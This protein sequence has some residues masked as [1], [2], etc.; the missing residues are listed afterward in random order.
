MS[1]YSVALLSRGWKI[2]VHFFTYPH[3]DEDK[4]IVAFFIALVCKLI[5]DQMFSFLYLFCIILLLWL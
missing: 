3:V 5:C 2:N 1:S 4:V